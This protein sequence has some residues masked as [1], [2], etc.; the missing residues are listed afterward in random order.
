MFPI[1]HNFSRKKT[2]QPSH[3]LPSLLGGA[4]AAKGGE[5]EG[6]IRKKNNQPQ[7]ST[8]LSY[9]EGQE[10]PKAARGRGFKYFIYD[11]ITIAQKHQVGT[12]YRLH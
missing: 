1:T 6:P 9:G 11:I 8:P 5:G 2:N 4:R 3:P 10:P 7:P 12:G